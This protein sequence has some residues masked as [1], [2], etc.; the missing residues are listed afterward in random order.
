MTFALLSIGFLLGL[1]VGIWDNQLERR[2]NH[3]EILRLHAIIEAQGR[4]Y[5][6]R[7]PE[8]EVAP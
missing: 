5:E 3:A 1:V 7:F 2:A 4:A 8:Q 6:Q